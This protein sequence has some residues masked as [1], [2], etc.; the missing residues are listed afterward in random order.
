MKAVVMVFSFV[1]ALLTMSLPAQAASDDECAIFLCLP[2]AFVPGACHGA[3]TA[4]KKRV[5]QMKSALPSFSS[6][7]VDAPDDL[8]LTGQ[9]SRME[10]RDGLAAYIPQHEVCRRYSDAGDD[11]NH[12]HCVGGW[13]T[14]PEQ[15]IK[16]TWCIQRSDDVNSP[17]RCTAT[18]NWAEV[19]MDGVQAGPTHYWRR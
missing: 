5:A 4:M 10:S 12:R 9:G 1:A 8:P 13:E 7:T 15:Y 17:P 11:V 2:Q 14:V 3:L 19:Y 16:G 18:Y 6:C